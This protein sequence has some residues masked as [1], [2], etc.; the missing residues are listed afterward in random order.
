MTTMKTK[1]DFCDGHQL[2]MRKSQNGGGNNAYKIF[3]SWLEEGIIPNTISY[4]AT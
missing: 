3:T 1:K 4:V 2:E